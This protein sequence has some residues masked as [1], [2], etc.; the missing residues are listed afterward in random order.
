MLGTVLS[1]FKKKK[2]TLDIL[3]L[4]SGPLIKDLPASVVDTGLIPCL[5]SLH[6]P[7]GNWAHA[8]QQ[9]VAPCSPQLE[10][11]RIQQWRPSTTKDK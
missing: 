7:R 4:C 2:Q 10:T 11:A 5:G 9:R 1:A 8:P 6:M 3:D